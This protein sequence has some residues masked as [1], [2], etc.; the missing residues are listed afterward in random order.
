MAD[1]K[2]RVAA[3]ALRASPPRRP[4]PWLRGRDAEEVWKLRPRVLRRSPQAVIKNADMSED[5]QQDA[6]DCASQAME[7]FNIERDLASC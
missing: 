1:R 4:E 7:K 6:I 5:M 3:A 2:V